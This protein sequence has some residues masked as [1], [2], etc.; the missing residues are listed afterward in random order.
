[1]A[2]R[3]I[4]VSRRGNEAVVYIIRGSRGVNF[5][6][7]VD[8]M[9]VMNPTATP[10]S[11][12]S[13]AELLEQLGNISASR[14]RR[15]P[16]PG[17]ATEADVI[18][19]LEAPRKRICELVDGTLVEKPMGYK[20]SFLAIHLGGLLNTFVIPRNLG[21]VSG[22]DGSVR[23]FAG[24]VRYPDIAFTSW[25]RIP[26]RRLPDAPIPDLVP[27]LTVEVLSLSNTDAE[28]ARKRREYFSA[29]VIL[30]WE[31]DPRSRTV[32]VYADP[33]S[34]TILTEA[35]TLTGDPVLPGFS[36]SLR[37]YFS[38]LDRHG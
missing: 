36:L 5:I 6:G 26:G 38:Q 7:G 8:T 19:A 21:L 25:D 18:A 28:M 11:D 4:G 1:M 31:I 27:N 34:P 37:D 2:P 32:H 14:V 3:G 17:T 15:H 30:V 29:G 20:E 33:D 10:A 9:P 12:D 35:D 13:L 23:L 16:P 22:S 24:L